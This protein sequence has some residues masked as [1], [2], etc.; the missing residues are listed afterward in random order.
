MI[1]RDRPRV[2]GRRAE[3]FRTLLAT[4]PKP[5][6]DTVLVTHYPNIIA[7]L[8]KD[9]FDVKEGEASLFQPGNGS[10]KLLTRIQMDE[11]PRIATSA[12][13]SAQR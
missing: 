11:W 7:A 3:A 10:Y 9:W 13:T 1:P 8:G 12:K 6:T 5:G 4:P 2:A